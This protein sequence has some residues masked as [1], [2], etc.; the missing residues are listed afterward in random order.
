MRQVGVLAAAGQF[1]LDHQGAMA[2]R[3]PSELTKVA[4]LSEDHKHARMIAEAVVKIGKGRLTPRQVDTNI[5]IVKVD[6][7]LATPRQVV[8][9]LAKVLR[10]GI[11]FSKTEFR[12]TLHCGITARLAELAVERL[13]STLV[14]FL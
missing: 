4:L 9:A 7:A 11:E 2:I 14:A 1:A 12:L 8:A 13:E 5:V 10:V 3:A 6:P